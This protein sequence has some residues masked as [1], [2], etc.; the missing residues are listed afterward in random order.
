MC[1]EDSEMIQKKEK[2]AL[3]SLSIGSL[4]FASTGLVGVLLNF[5]CRAHGAL[6]CLTASGLAPSH[7]PPPTHPQSSPLGTMACLSLEPTVTQLPGFVF[8]HSNG[9]TSWQPSGSMVRTPASL[10]DN[11]RQPG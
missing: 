7:S 1:W 6:R 8:C 2:L 11:S 4:I 10:G 5:N 3:L 9:F